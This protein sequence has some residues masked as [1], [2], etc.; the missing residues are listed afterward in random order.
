MSSP[1]SQVLGPSSQGQDPRAQVPGPRSQVPGPSAQ[2]H[3]HHRSQG[4]HR[5]VRL[6]WLDCLRTLETKV[7]FET[8][9]TK[10]TFAMI[11]CYWNPILT[12][13][14]SSE[15]SLYIH[16]AVSDG[17]C[18]MQC[19]QLYIGL[20]YW[21]SLPPQGRSLCGLWLP[22]WPE[23]ARL[24]GWSLWTVIAMVVIVDCDCHGGL[25]VGLKVT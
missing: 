7:T 3:G 2:V 13:A 21:L 10:D 19:C 16:S 23:V 5:G 4:H 11:K 15:F 20:N 24:P 18:P 1:R 6:I 12:A 9:E 14:C 8:F 25:M 22:G 17:L